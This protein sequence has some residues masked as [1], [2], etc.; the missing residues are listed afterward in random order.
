[1][2]KH[3]TWA[4]TLTCS[5]EDVRSLVEPKG[6]LSMVAQEAEMEA[7]ESWDHRNSWEIS[8]MMFEYLL[9]T[10]DSAL[11]YCSQTKGYN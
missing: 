8:Q 9:E 3:I 4:T 1:M 11:F 10:V 7:E 5:K 6:V 2:W